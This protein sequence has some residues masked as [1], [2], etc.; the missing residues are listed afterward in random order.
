MA[1]RVRAEYADFRIGARLLCLTEASLEA[2]SRRG[3]ASDLQLPR[4]T[5]LFH[6]C[7]VRTQ[8]AG[9]DRLG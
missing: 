9:G 1:P 3:V 5:E 2:S 7:I 4:M 8:A 6:R